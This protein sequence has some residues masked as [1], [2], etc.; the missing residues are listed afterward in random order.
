MSVLLSRK[1]CGT[2]EYWCGAREA[3]SFGSHVRCKTDTDEGL[4]QARQSP[5][6]NKEVKAGQT[7]CVKWEKWAGVPK[8]K[9]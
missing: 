8:M 5:R 6:K 3:D 4:C 2:C 1:A 9:G 7:A